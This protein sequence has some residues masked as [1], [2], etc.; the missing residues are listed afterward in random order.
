MLQVQQ[1]ATQWTAPAEGLPD[2]PRL[3]PLDK[4]G[5]PAAPMDLAAT[6]IGGSVL[7]DL[8]LK[9]ANTVPQFNTAWVARV[10]H[11]PQPLAGDLLE[12]LRSDGM[13]DV[14]GQAGPFGYRYAITPRG[15]A[16]A[17]RLLEMSTY[18]GPAPVTLAAYTAL[19]EWQLSHA[20]P[21]SEEDV[22]GALSRLVLPEDVEQL[23]GLASASGRSLFLHGP[24]GNGKTTLAR[25]LHGARAGEIWVPYCVGVDGHIIRVYDPLVHSAVEEAPK[26][27][28][29]ID[30]RWVRVRRPLIV[31]G[32]EMT[33]ET[34][35]LKYNPIQRFYEAPLHVKANGGTFLIDDFGRQRVDPHA[36]LNRWIIALEQQI[37]HLT[38]LTGQRIQVP[39]RHQLIF[40]TNL[41]LETVTDPAFLRRMGYRLHLSSPTPDQYRRIFELYAASRNL[42]APVDLLTWLLGR[43]ASEN[44]ELRGC[45]PRDL[46][47]RA[48]EI[49]RFRGEIPALTQQSMQLA[50]L[51]YF[52]SRQPR[53]G[54]REE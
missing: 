6:G 15:S 53:N 20:P 43:Y 36:L 21:V 50:W 48:C 4:W 51:G 3:V 18:V 47:E 44:R 28:W 54:R 22:A 19:L 31:V 8:A 12:S 2:L 5:V 33:L 24:P 34:L 11:L 39:C 45:E 37:D 42:A 40:A 49:C 32:G 46:I 38:L 14:L 41:D 30:Q 27:T 25:L 29:A 10:I 26:Q 7:F 16:R 9:A 52:G 13:L 17:T 23:A 35:E 1:S